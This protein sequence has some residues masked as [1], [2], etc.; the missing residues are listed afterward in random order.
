[1]PALQAAT[2]H[3]NHHLNRVY[4]QLRPRPRVNSPQVHTSVFMFLKT[5]EKW[6]VHISAHLSVHLMSLPFL[7]SGLY[8][9]AFCLAHFH[10]VCLQ[11]SPPGFSVPTFLH[12]LFSCQLHNLFKGALVFFLENR[13]SIYMSGIS[14]M[15][16]FGANFKNTVLFKFFATSVLILCGNTCFCRCFSPCP[17]MPTASFWSNVD[18]VFIWKTH[19]GLG[20]M[21]AARIWSHVLLSRITPSEEAHL[22]LSYLKNSNLCQACFSPLISPL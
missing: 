1:M 15:L 2:S 5:S 4:S 18:D 10:L 22:D 17:L 11:C 12:G 3:A 8:A 13:M 14:C 16:G 20:G 7:H 21:G 19:M 9:E 6:W